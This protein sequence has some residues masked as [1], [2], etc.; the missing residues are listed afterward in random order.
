MKLKILF[1]V[2]ATLAYSYLTVNAHASS[3]LSSSA[4]AESSQMSKTALIN[5]LKSGSLLFEYKAESF[6]TGLALDT[7]VEMHINGVFNRVHVTQSFINPSNDWA[8]GTYVFPLPENATV[9]AMNI[10]IGDRV[11]VGEIKERVE[12]KRLYNEAKKAGKKASLV[13]SQRPNV[14]TTNCLLYTSDAADEP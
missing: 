11:I 7:D 2:I 12:A 14:F 9:D 4:N 8:E 6:S 10:Q 5:E 3:P 13:E 1:I